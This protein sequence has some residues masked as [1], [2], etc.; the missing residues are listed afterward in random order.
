[1]NVRCSAVSQVG[2]GREPKLTIRII[3]R[4][5]FRCPDCSAFSGPQRPGLLSISHFR[6]IIRHLVKHNF[7]GV[8]NISG[9]ETTFHPQ[10]LKIVSLA[11]GH[12]PR[13]RI[14][15]FT[16]GDWVGR[17][18]WRSLLGSLLKYPNVL[19]RFSLDKEH[20][21]GKAQAVYGSAGA[22]GIAKIEK[23][24]LA[25]AR[26]FLEACRKEGA[27]PGL[28][29]DFAFKGTISE[30]QAYMAS[31]GDVPIYPLF[32]Q[33]NPASR[34]KQMG[35]LAVDLD[36][37]GRPLVFLTLGHLSR[38]E[39]MGGLDQLPLALAQ[40]REALKGFA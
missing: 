6:Q 29:F 2:V 30:G 32:F 21:E 10:L 8:L 15:V 35:F 12:L 3:R 34:P 25:K 22:D 39:S 11:S 36:P 38:G 26:L 24:R 7:H 18:R 17:P 31:L 16:N 14:V 28:N 33:R 9:G 20:A 13:A 1:M 4:C 27:Q 37:Q 23:E 40:N 19:V 5:G